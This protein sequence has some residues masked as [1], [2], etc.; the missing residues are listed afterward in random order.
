MYYDQ[1][2]FSLASLMRL[3]NF[4]RRA[5]T[6]AIGM[7]AAMLLSGCGSDAD[8]QSNSDAAVE[9]G[10]PASFVG[11]DACI[12]CHQGEAERWINSHHDSALEIA[13]AQ[14]VLGD[15]DDTQFTYQGVTSSFFIRNGE[16]WVRTDGDDGELRDF[17]VTH[18]IG[19]EPL[20]QYLIEMPR[21]H[22][23]ALSIAW[24]ARA[25]E[26]GGQRWFHLYPDEPISAQDPLHWTGTYQNWNTMCAECHST[27]LRK[28]YNAEEDRF[29]TQWSGIDVNCEACHGPGSQHVADPAVPPPA[30]RSLERAWVIAEGTTIATLSTNSD[31]SDEM[32]VCAQCHSRRSQLDDDFVPGEQ[33]LSSFRPALLDEGLYH[34]DGQILDEVYVY[35]SFMQ[36]AM[37]AAGVTCSDCHDPHSA[38]LYAEGNAVCGQCHLAT[39]FDTPEHHRHESADNAIEC[40]DCHMRAQT[41]M[42]VD[43]RRDHSFRVPRPDL[44]TRLNSPNACNDCHDDETPE[45]AALQ[46]AQWYPDGRSTTFHYGEALHAARTSAANSS[47]LLR[48]VI[49][50]ESTPAIVQATA[51]SLVANQADPGLFDLIR[52]AA[53]SPDPLVQLA[54]LDA[55]Q[56]L[57]LN[58]RISDAQRYLTSPLKTQRIAAARSLLPARDGLG[59]GRQ[60]DLDAALAEYAGVQRFN[61]DRG[62]GLL[63]LAALAAELGQFTLAEANYL[64]AL[65]REPAFSATYI[66]L[67]DLYRNTNREPAAQDLLR[68]GIAVNP[69]DAGLN[70]ALGLSLVR[71][72]D[73]EQALVQF[74][75]AVEKSPDSPYYAYVQAVALNSTDEVE[76]AISLLMAT[77]ERFPGHRET[78]LGLATMLRDAGRTQEALNYA[79]RLVALSPADQ[80]ARSLV[81]ELETADQ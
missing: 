67:A 42:V 13:T 20:Q 39:A 16:P 81:A 43:P 22:Y 15:F 51:V 75:N 19:I 36:S 38:Q 58:M 35:G 12:A 24:D 44:S 17:R 66:N 60:R 33:F 29:A 31:R 6:V 10:S 3:S 64:Q 27:E 78:L 2:G 9:P 1:P 21:G 76:A 14:N 77:H 59:P 62:E 61:S 40:V 28:N 73:V 5:L 8:I 32:Q 34:A 23:Q 74:A 55:T 25:A 79:R 4:A 37:A 71:S 80:V 11:G 56:T 72:G 41:Y 47:E 7:A 45:W 65:E 26:Q 57:P 52:V 63:N 49:A 68:A 50:D 69:D 70:L 48:R 46:V 53:N 54:A 18:T 30:L